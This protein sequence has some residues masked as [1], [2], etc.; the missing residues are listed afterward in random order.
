MIGQISALLKLPQYQC[1]TRQRRAAHQPQYQHDGL[2]DQQQPS[3][4][5]ACCHSGSA[6]RGDENSQPRNQELRRPAHADQTGWLLRHRSADRRPRR[7]PPRSSGLVNCPV[8]QHQGEKSGRSASANPDNGSRLAVKASASVSA[9]NRLWRQQM[10]S[11]LAILNSGESGRRR[12]LIGVFAGRF[13]WR[14]LRQGA[15]L[16][17]LVCRGP[18]LRRR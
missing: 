8:Q 12:K 4:C 5:S 11:G 9:T 14:H 16:G 3:T 17:G 6:I 15:A 18:A 1:C 7:R 2:R 13:F 10:S